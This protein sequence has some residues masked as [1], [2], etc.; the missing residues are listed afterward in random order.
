MAFAAWSR[1]DIAAV[2]TALDAAKHFGGAINLGLRPFDS[3][4]EHG[5]WCPQL[6]G[7]EDSPLW[8]LL[9]DGDVRMKLSGFPSVAA[10]VAAIEAAGG[11]DR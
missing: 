11:E 2:Q 4:E 7:S 5:R 1:P 3:A 8:V 9:C 6:D 10:L